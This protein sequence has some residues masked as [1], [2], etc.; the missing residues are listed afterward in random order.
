MDDATL[1]NNKCLGCHGPAGPATTVETHHTPADLNCTDCHN[2]MNPTG[3]WRH[4]KPTI[5][6]TTIVFGTPTTAP[7]AWTDFVDGAGTGLCEVCHAGTTYY[8][9]NGTGA[10]HMMDVCTNCH[11]HGTGFT[12]PVDPAD[13]PHD[14]ITDCLACHDGTDYF[15]GAMLDNAKCLVCHGPGGTAT[16]AA[17][18]QPILADSCTECHNVMRPQ[19]P[20]IKHIK[21]GLASF[22]ANAVWTDFVDGAGNGVCETCHTLTNY[23]NNS[24]TGAPHEMDVCTTCHEHA[25]GFQPTGGS[26]TTCHTGVPTGATYVTRD[27]VVGDF[28]QAS[29]HVF[30]GTVTDWDC[31]VCHREGDEN[32]AS[33]GSVSTT[34][35]HNNGGTPVVDM[36]DVDIINSGWVWDKNNTDDAMFTAMDNF[37][38]G[39][40]DIDG[41]SGI[42]VNATDN[43][44]N[45]SNARALTPFNSTDDVSEGIGGGTVNQAGYER[46]A[47]LDVATQF[48]PTNPSHHAVIAPAYN[49]HNNSW[50]NTAW[51]NRTLKSGQSLTT[52]Y[53][54]AQLHCADCHTVDSA[55]GGAHGGANGFMLQVGSGAETGDPCGD[56]V[57]SGIDRT[58][59]LC[60]NSTTYSDNSSNDTRWDHSND[61]SVWSP[62]DGSKLGAYGGA[63]GSVCL[64]CHGGDPAVDGFGGIHGLQSGLDWR[65]GQERFRFQG[66]SYMSHD[67]GDWTGT[68]GTATC[69]FAGGN[70]DTQ[71]WSNC[72]KHDAP[73]DGR[74]A[75]P[76]YSRP[77]PDTYV[78]P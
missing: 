40:H 4:I 61:S 56:S 75:P 18:H 58:C 63:T 28:T 32:A 16:E 17:A 2:P 31:I 41:A 33:S 53:E 27:V 43:G 54:T 73:E 9:D 67:P 14:T 48:D 45:L 59:W 50:G 71:D 46:T 52:V 21:T 8:N 12:P 6:L 35:L 1:D 66:G 72:T 13:T 65:S 44:V 22:T 51:V 57:C 15:A 49:S 26:C 24:G 20:N 23:Y 47:V 60:H 3:N 64:N 10:M 34:A 77:I 38:M 78:A 55:D 42:N 25:A 5:N 70:Q 11:T 19:T 62:D 69:Y 7:S 74:T 39:C 37:C 68:T 36:R 29:R 30:G 76:Q